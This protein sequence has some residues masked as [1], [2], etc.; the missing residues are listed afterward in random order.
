MNVDQKVKKEVALKRAVG[1]E[2]K[3]PSFKPSLSE[4]GVHTP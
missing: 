2:Q 4:L 1:A 3:G